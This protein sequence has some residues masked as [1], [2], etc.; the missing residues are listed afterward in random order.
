MD[1][2]PSST[3][4]VISSL[5]K[6]VI[7]TI[8]KLLPIKD[9][10][11]TSMLSRKWRYAWTTLPRL[12]FTDK[13]LPELKTNIVK[14]MD[15]VLS[16]HMGTVVKFHLSTRLHDV[17]DLDRWISILCD[18]GV[19]EFIFKL[20]WGAPYIVPSTLFSCESLKYL[21]LSNCTISIPLEFRAFDML[22]Y[23]H[24]SGVNFVDDGLQNLL[25]KCPH[26]TN[27][28]LIGIYCR[29]F[30]KIL[31]PNLE[32]FWFS[33][34]F[35]DLYFEKTPNLTDVHIYLIDSIPSLNIGVQDRRVPDLMRA[36]HHLGSIETLGLCGYALKFLLIGTVQESLNLT[37]SHL[38][39][40]RLSLNFEDMKGTAAVLRLLRDC[41]FLQELEI[42]TDS[43]QVTAMLPIGNYWEMVQYSDCSFNHLHE[44]RMIS[45]S[46]AEPELE[47]MKYI[48]ANATVLETLDLWPADEILEDPEVLKEMLTF[49]RASKH[50]AIIWHDP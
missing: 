2:Q 45:F 15:Q 19:Q 38:K 10:V 39:T 3:S 33:G 4:D 11:R 47:F 25:S 7:D 31:A 35:R 28:S 48:L 9:A 49:Q 16:R 44:V 21:K 30:L 24:L 8:L 29:T 27:L 6:D 50:A 43:N 36:L 17:P 46:A 5:P 14:I 26:L 20:D 1:A 34:T 23:L 22:T 41:P 37:C 42:M 32:T 12:V 18:K 40:L 13:Q